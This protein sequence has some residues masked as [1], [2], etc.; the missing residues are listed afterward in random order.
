MKLNQL[1]DMVAAEDEAVFQILTEDRF[2]G[3]ERD[4]L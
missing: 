2:V 1:W 4:S 3:G